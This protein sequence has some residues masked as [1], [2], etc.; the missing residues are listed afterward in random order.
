M[1]DHIKRDLL[2]KHSQLV[3]GSKEFTPVKNVI[4]PII[5]LAYRAE[6][7]DI[8]DITIYIDHSQKYFKSLLVKLFHDKWAR[9]NHID[10]VI[11]A[12]VESYIDH[13]AA[14]LKNVNDV[15]PEV[16]PLKDIAFCNQR[17]MLASPI[18][19]KHAYGPAEL[20]DMESVGW[21]TKAGG[22]DVD[23]EEAVMLAKDQNKG[24][25]DIEV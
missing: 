19:I 22:A 5:N 13:G 16:V 4:K 15:K 24:S 14:L 1:K 6:G 21:G 3:Q 8:K 9:E 2:Y 11:D 23:L 10:T 12:M 25:G 18:G 7:F 20:L 17:D